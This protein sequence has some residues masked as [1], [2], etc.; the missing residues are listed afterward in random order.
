MDAPDYRWQID[1]LR[2]SENGNRW[3]WSGDGKV[4]AD[5][6]FQQCVLDQDCLIVELSE[7]LPSA[8]TIF[9][10]KVVRRQF[11]RFSDGRTD[12]QEGNELYEMT[13]G[14]DARAK[15]DEFKSRD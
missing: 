12:T 5:M 11:V 15:L 8:G 13:S 7:W 10:R 3:D 9:D 4:D 1:T 2:L 14:D 6:R